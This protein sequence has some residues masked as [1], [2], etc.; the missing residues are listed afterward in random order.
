MLAPLIKACRRHPLDRP[1]VW[2]M[3]Q[4]GRYMAEYRKIR[5]SHSILEICKTPRL[6]AEVTLQPVDALGVDAAIIFADLLL[7]LEPMGLHLEFVAGD[8]PVIHN[9]VRSASDVE[10]LR[11]G[12]SDE[13]AYVGEAIAEAKKLLGGRVPLIGFVGAPFTL[14]SYMIEGGSSRHYLRAKSLMYSEPDTWR[15]LMEKLVEALI[16]YVANQVAR[17]AEVIQVFDSWVGA[18]GPSDYER[19]VLP[20]SR[21]LIRAIQSTGVPVIHFSTGGS[22]YLPLLQR[23][24]GE[25]LGL[26]WRVHLDEAW[27]SIHHEAAVQ[28]NLDPA[29]LFAPLPE[30]RTRVEDILRRAGNRPGFI[31]NLGHG[32]LPETPVENVKAVVEMVREYSPSDGS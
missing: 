24:G 26:D 4:A 5:K 6:A 23:A 9:P 1:P 21:L 29:A 22:G 20:H 31:F 7:P 19:H 13:L 32:I 18:L 11:A 30:L 16:P 17:G 8:G 14:A 2:F 10:A 3:R 28:G 15:R 25:V 12:G 27:S